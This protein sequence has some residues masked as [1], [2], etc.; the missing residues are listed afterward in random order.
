MTTAAVP[1][2]KRPPASGF[3][4]GPA[5]RAFVLLAGGTLSLLA[6]IA[7]ARSFSG[8]AP[9]HSHMRDLAILI[10]V[11][12]VVPAIPLGAYLLLARKGGARH[13]RLGKI[14]LALMVT[15]ACAAIFIKTSGS[16]SPIHIFIPMTLFASYKVIS[17]ARKGDFRSH[18][19]H[20]LS[21]Y[22]GALTIP[23]IVAFAVPG[24]MMNVLLLW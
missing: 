1:L 4:I 9:D 6:I 13:K 5:L 17:S 24:R 21:L 15:T 3:D 18:R 14:W 23:G 8:V 22:L 11:G 10:H 19:I 2:S 16:F 20:I 12:S 7:L